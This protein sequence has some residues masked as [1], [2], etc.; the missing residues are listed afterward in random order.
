MSREWA[1]AASSRRVD[2]TAWASAARAAD[3]VPAAPLRH[4]I[5]AGV[6]PPHRPLTWPPGPQQQRFVAAVTSAPASTL[7]SCASPAAKLRLDAPDT[8][9]YSWQGWNSPCHHSQRR[10]HTRSCSCGHAWAGSPGRLMMW[11]SARVAVLVRCGGYRPAWLPEPLSSDPTAHQAG[12]PLLYPTASWVG[13]WA[14]TKIQSVP[15]LT[16]CRQRWLGLG[17]ALCAPY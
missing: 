1:A 6:L 16:R 12:A 13:A 2:D 7:A 10:F 3:R 15:T 9:C 11:R 8:L 14:S 4:S 17:L 5:K